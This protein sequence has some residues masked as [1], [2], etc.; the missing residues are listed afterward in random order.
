MD[1]R[2][3]RPGQW[4]VNG[5]AQ[6]NICELIGIRPFSPTRGAHRTNQ[7]PIPGGT[8]Y[9]LI[10]HSGGNAR[11]GIGF[12]A[13]GIS[14]SREGNMRRFVTAASATLLGVA[15]GTTL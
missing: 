6:T 14:P 2:P 13:P 1:P 5:T 7:S 3:G 15:L 11:W 10:V 4:R 9:S 12:R 8:G